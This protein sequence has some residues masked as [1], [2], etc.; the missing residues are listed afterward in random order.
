VPVQRFRTFE[1]AARAL[2][3]SSDDPN[4][5]RRIRAVWSRARRFAPPVVRRGVRRYRS[6][7]DA[8]AR[9]DR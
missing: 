7:G 5:A 3:M 2:W 8:T 4:L 1:E 6:V 9:Q